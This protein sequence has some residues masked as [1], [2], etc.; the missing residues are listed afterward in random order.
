M[1]GNPIVSA[2]GQPDH[3]DPA[4]VRQGRATIQVRSVDCGMSVS[5]AVP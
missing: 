4:D 1:F 5:L 2:S 3:G